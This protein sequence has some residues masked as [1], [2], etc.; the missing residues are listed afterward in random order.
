M[1]AK[2]LKEIERR[3]AEAVKEPNQ[4]DSQKLSNAIIRA[5]E[6]IAEE[7]RSEIASCAPSKNSDPAS[8]FILWVSN[9]FPGRPMVN[10]AVM[11]CVISAIAFAIVWPITEACGG[12]PVLRHLMQ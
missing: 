4:I 5:I 9:L 11:G 2:H 7:R 1:K 10:G 8:R 6:L 3:V 12:F